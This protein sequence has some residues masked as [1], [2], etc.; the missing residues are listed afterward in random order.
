MSMHYCQQT[1]PRPTQYIVV[2]KRCRRNVLA[3]VDAFPLNPVAV[4]C[5]LCGE[6]RR[7]RPSEV[8]LGWPDSLVSAAAATRRDRSFVRKPPRSQP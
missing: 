2:C 7:Y 8:Y 3:C 1:G 5:P 6:L 4:S